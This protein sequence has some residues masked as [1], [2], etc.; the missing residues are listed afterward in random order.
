MLRKKY[1]ITDKD[2]LEAIRY[3]TTG[4]RDMGPL[5]KVVYVADKLE[6]SRTETSPVLKK[7]CMNS[8]LE[9]L[10]A[11]VL[12]NTVSHLRHRQLDISYGTKRLLAAMQRRGNGEKSEV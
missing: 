2:I 1:G 11:A 9:N 8:S 3:H 4:T 10:F 6:V 12:N 7:I 5:A